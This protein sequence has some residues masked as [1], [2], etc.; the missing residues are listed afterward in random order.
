MSC[1]C[2]LQQPARVAGKGVQ[3][4]RVCDI[5][6]NSGRKESKTEKDGN[7]DGEA[8]I[9]ILVKVKKL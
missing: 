9:Q 6:S 1:I 2:F 3:I 5:W 7:R 4:N 8:N